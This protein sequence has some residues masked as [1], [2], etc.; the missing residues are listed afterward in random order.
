M[1]RFSNQLRKIAEKG[2]TLN[3]IEFTYT[4]RAHISN[5]IEGGGETAIYNELLHSKLTYRDAPLIALFLAEMSDS[6]LNEFI[7]DLSVV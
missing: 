6:E 3:A 1:N 5:C 7:K 4:I 2:I